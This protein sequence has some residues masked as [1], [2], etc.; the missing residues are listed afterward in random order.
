MTRTSTYGELLEALSKMSP[1]QLK[2]NITLVDC[3]GEYHGV[4]FKVKEEEEDDVLDK[5]HPFLELDRHE[6]NESVD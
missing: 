6:I 3:T 1:G 2:S 4:H 5:G